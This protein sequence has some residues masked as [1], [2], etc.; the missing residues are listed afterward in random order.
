M[1]S[2]GLTGTRIRERRE[3]LGKGQSELA[4]EVGISGAYL[5]LIEHNRRRIG[6]KLLGDIARQL[7][8]SVDSL[9][10]GADSELIAALRDAAAS[11]PEVSAEIDRVEE[12][13]GRFE[14]WAATVAALSRRVGLL[15]RMVESLTD[16]LAHDPGLAVSL[17]EVLSTATGIKSAAAILVE[18]E[19]IQDE[20][21]DRFHRNIH[22]DSQ[23]L[24]DA[25]QSLVSY[26]DLPG[27]EERTPGLPQ[28][29]VELWLAARDYHI[30]ELEHEPLATVDSLIM[31]PSAFQ[32]LSGRALA[33]RYLERYRH[34]AERMPLRDFQ[35]R[36]LDMEFDPVALSAAFEVDLAAVLRRI[37]ALP[38][39]ELGLRVGFVQCDSSGT[40]TFRRPVDGF[41]LP[42]FGAACPLWPLFQALGRPLMPIRALVE[43]CGRESVRFLVYAIAQPLGAVGFEASQVFEGTMLM[44]PANSVAL[45]DQPV[46]SVGTNCRICPSESCEVRREIS[47]FSALGQSGQSLSGHP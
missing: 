7:G 30:S 43:M 20:W 42:R 18:N 31:E 25:S 46:I 34:D 4:K 24:A 3:M 33:R 35:T 5:S 9:A 39:A 6:G 23:R 15:E 2:Q 8:V 16:R 1:P 45:P 21:R 41:P 22:E 19:N 44:L 47:I 13:A 40:L 29:E 37:V 38:S 26:L 14:G 11:V 32:S 17:H 36:A 27:S 28:E 10:D 12:F